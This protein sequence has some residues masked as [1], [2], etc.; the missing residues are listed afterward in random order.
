M[1]NC[2]G[3]GRSSTWAGEGVA[4]EAHRDAVGEQSG[5]SL[6]RERAEERAVRHVRS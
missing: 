2:A 5:Q 6:M 1:E 4:G 3:D